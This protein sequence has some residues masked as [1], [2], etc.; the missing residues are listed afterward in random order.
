MS[1][2]KIRTARLTDTFGLARVLWD[3]TRGPEGLPNVRS[4]RQDLLLLAR[5]VRR[6]AVRLIADSRGPCAFI[7]RNRDEIHALYV[8]SRARRLGLGRALLRDAKQARLR[9]ALWTPTG[10]AIA[11]H[12]Y[13]GEGFRPMGYGDGAGNDEALPEVFLLWEAP[14]ADQTRPKEAS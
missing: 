3:H 4:R 1:T 2:A 8:H 12:F 7:A 10:A 11:R 13:A 6:G 9:L 5:L 14:G